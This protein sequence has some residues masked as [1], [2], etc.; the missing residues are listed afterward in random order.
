MFWAFSLMVKRFL[1][2][3]ESNGSIPLMPIYCL[4][5]PQ[6][7]IILN[8]SDDAIDRV[9]NEIIARLIMQTPLSSFFV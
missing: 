8:S 1:H 4:N 3:E 5:T 2:T 7:L 6:R 9:R